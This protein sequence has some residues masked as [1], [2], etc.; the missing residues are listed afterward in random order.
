M[1]PSIRSTD[2]QPAPAP[3]FLSGAGSSRPGSASDR[4]AGRTILLVDDDHGVRVGLA[5][6]LRSDGW[7]VIA[8]AS[9]AEALERLNEQP[10]DLLITDLRM[11]E[12]SGWDL[13]FHER[14]HRPDM[15][16]FVISALQPAVLAGVERFATG[17]FQKPL[18]LD[19]LLGAVRH[20]LGFSVQ[21][22][23]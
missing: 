8:A 4:P 1:P 16:I 19:L 22:T 9:G 14:L 3:Q 12:V 21:P 10:P 18:D 17:F 15:P 2:V 20:R 13:L 6:A 7:N 23:T 11:A 5:R